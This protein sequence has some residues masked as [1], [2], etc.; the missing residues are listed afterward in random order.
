MSDPYDAQRAFRRE[1]RDMVK[2]MIAVVFRERGAELDEIKDDLRVVEHRLSAV[3]TKQ[4]P[5]P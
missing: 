3:E 1:I 4:A 2:D 5:A